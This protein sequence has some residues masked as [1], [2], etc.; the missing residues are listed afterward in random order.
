MSLPPELEAA[1]SLPEMAD[2]D[3]VRTIWTAPFRLAVVGIVGVGK[4]TLAN[5]LTESQAPTGLGGVTRGVQPLYGRDR[6]VLD[7]EGIDDE[8]VARAVL[9]E[10]LESADGVVWVVDGRAPSTATERRLLHELLPDH[11][12]HHVVVARADLLDADE[13]GEV[14]ARVARLHPN[15]ASIHLLDLRTDP[16]PEAILATVLPS[17]ARRHAALEA[18]NAALASVPEPPDPEPYLHDLRRAWRSAVLSTRDAVLADVKAGTLPDASTALASLLR[19]SKRAGLHIR[20]VLEAEPFLEELGI[21]AP[22]MPAMRATG[23][24]TLTIL[25]S[26]IAGQAGATRQVRAAAGLWLSDGDMALLDW[27]QSALTSGI[28]AR[29]HALGARRAAYQAAATA[30]RPP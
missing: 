19:A 23:D 15:A 28:Q 22:R 17:P 29:T 16:I 24:S 12:P 2:P 30:L 10:P 3:R 25:K 11:T 9:P 21:P 26:G 5:R 7:T 20:Q 6:V 8:R 13:R 27:E 18:V 14:H 4:T 1:L